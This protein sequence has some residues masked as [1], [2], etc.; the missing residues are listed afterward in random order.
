VADLVPVSGMIPMRHYDAWAEA[1]GFRGEG[2]RDG[3]QEAFART[4]YIIDYIGEQ[5]FR[6]SKDQQKDQQFDTL[7][8]SRAFFDQVGSYPAAA[9]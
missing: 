5:I 2:K 9:K 7:E 1:S 3:A 8:A 4:I 6:F